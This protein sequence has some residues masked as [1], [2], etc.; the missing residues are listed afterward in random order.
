MRRRRKPPEPA[1]GGVGPFSGAGQCLA[2][3]HQRSA[4]VRVGDAGV[5]V[6]Q[7]ERA[8]RR[9]VSIHR[10]VRRGAVLADQGGDGDVERLA[11]AHQSRR[12][13]AVVAALVFLH[14]LEGKPKSVGQLGLAH[15]QEDASRADAGAY[16]DVDRIRSGRH[17][18]FSPLPPWFPEGAEGRAYAASLVNA[19]AMVWSAKQSPQACTRRRPRR[20]SIRSSVARTCTNGETSARAIVSIASMPGAS[21]PSRLSVSPTSA[22][23]RSRSCA[24]SAVPTA[25]GESDSAR[26]TSS[27]SYWSRIARLNTRLEN[28]DAPVR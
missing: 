1:L 23:P 12:R 21:M 8:R 17:R 6:Q 14:L 15:A 22:T 28:A 5:G 25:V 19:T 2:E 4:H 20:T 24:A 26:M 10:P 7:V 13:N 18:L 11:D 9:Q 16:L 3:A 27:V